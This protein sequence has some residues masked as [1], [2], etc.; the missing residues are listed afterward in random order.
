MSTTASPARTGTTVVG[1]LG[2][3]AVDSSGTETSSP[4]TLVAVPGVRARR[5]LVALVLAGGRA[6]STERLIGDVW[7]DL[8]PK[9]P[10]AALQTQISRLRQLLGS[11][12]IEGL[13]NGYRLT[14]CRTD[15]EIVADLIEAGDAESLR[16]AA[17][18]WRGAPGEDLGGDA[19]G[20]ADEL[21]TRARRLDEELD[22]RRISVAMATGDHTTAVELA[23]K[24]CDADPLDETA[25]VDLM[26]ALAGSGRVPDALAVFARLR[27]ALSE[28]LGVDPGL[29]AVALNAELLQKD[30]VPTP[31]TPRRGRV[32]GLVAD[33]TELIGRDDDIATVL[34]LLERHRVVT[35]QGPGGVGKTR[36]ANRVGYHIADTGPQVYYV[37]L[38]PVR[39]ADDLVPAIAAALGVGETDLGGSGR[40]RLA[41]GDLADRLVDAIRG[42]DTL[43]ILDNCEQV[44]D[45]CAQVVADLLAVEPRVRILVT[46][47]SP[48]LLAAEQIYLLPVLD[49]GVTGPAVALF[50][51]RARAIRPDAYLPRDTIAEMCRHLDGL[52][53]AIE[54]AAARV[55]TMTVEE[56]GRRLAERFALLRGSDRSAPDR[57]RTLY[58]VIDW[59]WELLDDDAR[60]ALRR[61]CR[62]PA[63]FTARAA[64]T[65][66]G[67]RGFRLDDTLEA[68]VNQSLLT[69]AENGGQ[70]R[71]RMLETVREFG[72]DKLS[73][74]SSAGT[75]ES[76]DVDAAMRAWAIE[77]ATQAMDHYDSGVD[78]Q[79]MTLL[80][81]EVDNLVWILRRAVTGMEQGARDDLVDTVVQVFPVLTGFWMARG[82]N[83]EVFSWGARVLPSLPVPPR[84]VPPGL[85]RSWQA[86]VLASMA[87]QMMHRDLRLLATGR[88]YLRRLHRP[89]HVY[90]VPTELISACVLSRHPLAAIRYIVRGTQ[91]ADEEVRTAALSIRMNLRENFGHLEGALQDGL[92][93]RERAMTS[94]DTWMAAMVHVSIGSVYG[95]QAQW[96]KAIEYYRTG[97]RR[98]A[99]LGAREDEMQTRCYLVA[100]L[101]AAG[102]LDGSAELLAEAEAELAVI[103]DGWTPADP[104]PQGSPEVTASMMVST[105]ELEMT[106]GNDDVAADLYRRAAAV[107]KREHPLGARDPGVGMLVAVTVAGLMRAGR[108]D[109][110]R[111]FLPLLEDGVVETFGALGWQDAPQA[112]TMLLAYGYVLCAD[113][114]TRATGARLLAMARRMRARQDYW[115]FYVTMRDVADLPGLPAD[116]WRTIETAMAQTPRHQVRA[117]AQAVLVSRR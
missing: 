64:G 34:G 108:T 105:A 99:E 43:I 62:F 11:A 44:I 3:V 40:P 71:Y 113:G 38:A 32:A 28:H 82:L 47:R 26:R 110:A 9:A 104:D 35:V 68:L 86:T 77:F 101:V 48:L 19:D 75:D 88:Y 13:G 96:H 67:Y 65:I 23:E 79:L 46:S 76:R 90:R 12:S 116:E 29:Q 91:A 109:S 54:L 36:V 115:T 10:S 17:R 89:D 42:R 8:P 83:A 49:A 72:E 24:R 74:G 4:D 56:I 92:A 114:A 31:A 84:D 57:H 52:P 100:N 58:A 73:G 63:G 80:D 78:G 87:H 50:E 95:Q 25:H 60:S 27:R 2:P 41:V 112:G 7:G 21:S 16:T 39:D 1:V 51:A 66:V 53:L 18:W 33:S 111:E 102:Q 70:V 117:Q 45:R 94:D 81:A 106:R 55:R 93:M 98:L 22:R 59:S 103:A 20:L 5:L 30:S 97:L 85:R 69:V 14:G 107:L 61:L 15:L 37:P 6:R